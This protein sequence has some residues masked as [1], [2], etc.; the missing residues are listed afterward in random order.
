MLAVTSMRIA[1]YPEFSEF[2][3]LPDIQHV[4]FARL[5]RANYPG[6]PHSCVAECL[7]VGKGVSESTAARA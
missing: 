4:C 2:S 5:V 7:L 1:E 6:T 3:E